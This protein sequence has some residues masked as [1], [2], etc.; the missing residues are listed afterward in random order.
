MAN[1]KPIRKTQNKKTETVKA[2]T[3]E[4]ILEE[5]HKND[6]VGG[7]TMRE[8]A[9]ACGRSYGWVHEHLVLGGYLKFAGLRRVLNAAQVRSVVPVYK[10]VRKKRGGGKDE[11][12]R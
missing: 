12:S 10:L 1:R 6:Y 8:I 7:M 9:A 2:P 4:E 3:L 11:P 5:L